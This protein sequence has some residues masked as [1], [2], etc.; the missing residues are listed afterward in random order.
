M[1]NNAFRAFHKLVLNH[2]MHDN[3]FD[4]NLYQEGLQKERFEPT[5]LRYASTAAC[6]FFNS[7]YS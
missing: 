2:T 4:L 3:H 5:A 7:R 6:V 1:R